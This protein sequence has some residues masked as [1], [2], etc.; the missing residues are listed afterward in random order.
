MFSNG[1]VNGQFR[2]FYFDR[3]FDGSTTDR[4]DFSVG[5]LFSYKTD[6]L[7][8][9]SFGVKFATSNDVGSDDDKDVYGLLKRGDSGDHESFTRLQEYYVQGEWFKTRIKYGAQEINTPFLN[10]HDVRMAP[11][12]YKGLAVQN[13]SINNLELQGYWLTGFMG[14]SDEEFMDIEESTGASGDNPLLVLGAKYQFPLTA[15]KL[16]LEGWHYQMED[17]FRTSLF[18]VNIGKKIGNFNLFMT[19]QYTVQKSIGDDDAG[20]IDTDQ[21]GL[22]AGF[23]A[24]GITFTG[25]YFTMGDDGFVSPWGGKALIQQVVAIDRAEEDSYGARVAYDFK[26]LGLKGLNAYIFYVVYDTPESGKNSS[27]DIA[28]TDYSIQ[29]SF[30]DA[31]D[32]YLKGLALRARYADVRY[33]KGNDIKDLRLYI[34]YNF[35]FKNN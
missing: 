10:T 24:Y 33:D 25:Y 16:K 14:W 6:E 8:G 29:Y 31:F 3:N 18:T 21:Y 32:G 9:I 4:E 35:G 27:S 23:G 11:K 30:G 5:G 1:S 12:T 13:N 7:Y 26:A 2:T 17:V 34:T 28:E 15:V 22:S 19:P 20:D